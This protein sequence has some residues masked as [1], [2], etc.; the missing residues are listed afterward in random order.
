LDLLHLRL[1][2]VDDSTVSSSDYQPSWTPKFGGEAKARMHES[3][4]EFSAG[5]LNTS[6]L[7]LAEVEDWQDYRVPALKG[8]FLDTVSDIPKSDVLTEQTFKDNA[9]SLQPKPPHPVQCT[10]MERRTLRHTS[11]LAFSAGLS[12][13]SRF[14]GP[15]LPISL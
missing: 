1:V 11:S 4:S 2:G 7:N 8:L 14:W 6:M 5:S 9:D 3:W 10:S 15:N 13:T 12:L